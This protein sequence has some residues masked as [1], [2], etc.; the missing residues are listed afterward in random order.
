MNKEAIIVVVLEFI[1]KFFILF[2]VCEG[3]SQKGASLRRHENNDL[4]QNLRL[5]IDN[6][7]LFVARTKM[8]KKNTQKKEKEKN[9]ETN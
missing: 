7:K 6:Q 5:N 2:L 8:T 3:R 1:F 4:Q 9:G